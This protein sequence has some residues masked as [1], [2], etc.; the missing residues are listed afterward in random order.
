M[1]KKLAKKEKG[2]IYLGDEMGLRSDH[3][4][5]RTYGVKGKTPV[6]K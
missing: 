6:V 4:V 5:G 1:I 2:T 3:N